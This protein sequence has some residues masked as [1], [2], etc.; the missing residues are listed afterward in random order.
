MGTGE[1]GVPPDEVMI[2]LLK[3][4]KM[5]DAYRKYINDLKTGYVIEVNQRQWEKILNT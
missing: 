2:R 4:K 1:E 3:R 5:E